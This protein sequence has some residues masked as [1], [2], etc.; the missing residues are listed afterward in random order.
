M[1]IAAALP[2]KDTRESDA[3]QLLALVEGSHIKPPTPQRSAMVRNGMGA[4]SAAS[5]AERSGWVQMLHARGMRV[6]LPG[7]PSHYL[8][9]GVH[10]A[11]GEQYASD[12]WACELPLPALPQ[13]HGIQWP[14]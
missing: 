14:W 8:G 5:T 3:A 7:G 13:T 1:P 2:L 12:L 11:G 9:D 6:L 4:R 10:R